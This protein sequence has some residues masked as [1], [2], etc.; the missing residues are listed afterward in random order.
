MFQF[1]TAGVYEVEFNLILYSLATQS[2]FTLSI[3]NVTDLTGYGTGSMEGQTQLNG[4]LEFTVKYILTAT[5]SSAQFTQDL[6][7]TGVGTIV[8]TGSRCNI[9]RLY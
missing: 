5:S 1:P 3:N 8:R 7:G 9:K 2:D 4:G 6:L